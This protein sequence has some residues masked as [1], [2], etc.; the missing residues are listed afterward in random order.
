MFDSDSTK[1]NGAAQPALTNRRMR[2]A[3]KA[4]ARQGKPVQLTRQL[5]RE[6]VGRFSSRRASWLAQGGEGE[7]QS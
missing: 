7:V 2:R 5:A 6:G 1:S 3:A 4:C